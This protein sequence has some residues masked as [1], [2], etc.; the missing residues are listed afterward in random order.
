LV[1]FAYYFRLNNARQ[2]SKHRIHTRNYDVC[3]QNFDPR[4]WRSWA[5]GE[6]C[7]HCNNEGFSTFYEKGIDI[8]AFGYMCLVKRRIVSSYTRCREQVNVRELNMS[9]RK[10]RQKTGRNKAVAQNT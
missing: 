10:R 2:A 9:A 1:L 4:T 5:R 8:N 7:Q 6:S 3:V